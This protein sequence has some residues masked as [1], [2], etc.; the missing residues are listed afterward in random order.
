MAHEKTTNHIRNLIVIGSGA[1]GCTAAV[2]AAH[3]NLEPLIFEGSV[4]AGGA[5]MTTTDVENFPGLPRRD[6]GS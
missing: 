1:A 5:L 2:Y 4:S 6:H 3:A